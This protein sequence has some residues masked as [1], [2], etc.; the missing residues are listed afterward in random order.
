MENE[1]KL[2]PEF[3]EKWI[4]ALRSG[5]YKQCTD[6]QMINEIEN[7]Y[8]C[9]AVACDI[10]GVQ[11]SLMST[12]RP[13]LPELIRGG[14]NNKIARKLIIMN[15]GYAYGYPE[16]DNIPLR[17]HSFNEIADYIQENL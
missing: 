11:R 16:Y 9:L 12:S 14:T 13:E 8:C 15:D 4:A 10:L 6:H 17:S 3:K 5:E 7:T 1:N 2:P